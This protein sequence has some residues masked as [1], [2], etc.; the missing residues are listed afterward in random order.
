MRCDGFI[1]LSR[2]GDNVLDPE[3]K[4]CQRRKMQIKTSFIAKLCS[5]D[6]DKLQNHVRMYLG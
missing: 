1:L 4:S 3:D 2:F 5:D 6:D